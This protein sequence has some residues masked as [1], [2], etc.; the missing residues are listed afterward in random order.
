MMSLVLFVLLRGWTLRPPVLS[1]FL[2]NIGPISVVS[3]PTPFISTTITI[4]SLKIK[5]ACVYDYV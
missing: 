5:S 4:K 1:N 2:P 3:E